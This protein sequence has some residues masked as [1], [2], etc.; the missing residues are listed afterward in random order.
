MKRLFPIL[1]VIAGLPACAQFVPQKAASGFCLNSSL[2]WILINTSA[3]ST[4]FIPQ[5][6]IKVYGA[7]NNAPA[8]LACDGN[9]N[10]TAGAFNQG[11]SLPS[12][13]SAGQVFATVIAGTATYYGCSSANTWTGLGGSG[14][15]I[16]Q[17]IVLSTTKTVTFSAIPQTFTDLELII[18]GASTA[19]SLDG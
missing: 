9:G 2:G 17:Q 8:P 11:S 13:C 12:S 16:A 10:L 15:Q 5:E 1:I 7:N 14:G 19:A 4:G 6:A 18:Q 3:A